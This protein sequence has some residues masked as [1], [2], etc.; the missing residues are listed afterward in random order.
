[1]GLG[2]MAY[3]RALEVVS[4][5]TA[6][7]I[8][9]SYPMF[10]IALAWALFR[11]KPAPR[12][13]FSGVIILVAAIM[14]LGAELNGDD[15]DV[16]LVVFAAPLSFGFAIAVL[17]ERLTVLR[18]IERVAPIAAGSTIGLLPLVAVQPW[19]QAVPGDLNTW[20]LAIGIALLT[21]VG[22]SGCIRPPPQTSERHVQRLRGRSTRPVFVRR[23]PDRADR[24]ANTR[25]VALRGANGDRRCTPTPCLRRSSRRDLGHSMAQDDAPHNVTDRPGKRHSRRHGQSTSTSA[26]AWHDVSHVHARAPRHT[27]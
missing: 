24:V 23:C 19:D 1:M 2:W 15:A 25:S 4:V 21:A 5:S 6:G 10:A 18:P 22:P 20:L 9:M 27:D 26:L 13:L 3:V 14:A 7:V 16:L 8:Y 17:T 11:E 12:A